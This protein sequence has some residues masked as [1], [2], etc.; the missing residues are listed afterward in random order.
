MATTHRRRFPRAEVTPE[1]PIC[2]REPLRGKRLARRWF[3]VVTVAEFLGFSIP[4]VAGALTA[5][6]PLALPVLLLAG[7][8][9]GAAL[10]FGQALVLRR[11]LPALNA[12]HWVAATASAAAFA[13]LLGLAPST[14][15]AALTTWPPALLWPVAAVLGIALLLSIGFAQWLVLRHLLARSARWVVTTAA[16]WLLGLAVFLGFTMPLW[17]PGQ[18]LVTTVLIGVFG[19]LLMAATTSAVTGFALAR[20]T[21]AQTP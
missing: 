10:G 16:A 15:A 6:H 1:T 2:G 21:P 7:A 9:E 3:L 13:Y 12:R 17:Q 8:A 4:A 11:A 18:A 14:W 20:L 19:G 5:D